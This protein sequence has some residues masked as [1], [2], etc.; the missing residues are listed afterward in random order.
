MNELKW[1]KRFLALA[2]HV[3]EWSKDPRTKVGS[4]IVDS[5]RRV[6]SMG[7]NGF[8]RGMDDSPELYADR[9]YKS[10]RMCHAER[11]ALDNSP[12]MVEGCTLYATLQPCKE[13]AK[14]I[15]QK[16]ITRVVTYVTER[17]DAENRFDWDIT[18][19]TFSDANVELVYIERE[20][21]EPLPIAF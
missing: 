20:Q 7:Y 6:V 3:A 16:G 4:V 10:K 13:C 19:E 11:N 5:K 2:E 17:D 1:D 15:A 18:I 14:S 8:P 12:L 9:E 21:P